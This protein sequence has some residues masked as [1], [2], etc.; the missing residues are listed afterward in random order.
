MQ[1]VGTYFAMFLVYFAVCLYLFI[2]LASLVSINFGKKTS[3]WVGLIA[4]S[5][6]VQGGTPICT[7]MEEN[8]GLFA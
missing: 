1:K 8:E 6:M 5:G 4:S 3:K 7:H 2:G